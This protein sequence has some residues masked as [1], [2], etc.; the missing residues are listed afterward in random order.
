[1][2]GREQHGGVDKSLPFMFFNETKFL[3]RFDISFFYIRHY[4]LRS[5]FSNIVKQ[6]GRK[7]T[8]R[9]DEGS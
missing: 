7:V 2:K 5:S 9:Y 1:M 6:K 3:G 4:S 8:G